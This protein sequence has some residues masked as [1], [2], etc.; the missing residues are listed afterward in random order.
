METYV[1][2]TAAQFGVRYTEHS[3]RWHQ[4][5]TVIK[6]AF[7]GADTDTDT[8]ILAD[9][10]ARIVERMSACRSAWHRNN[11]KKSGVGRV[12]EDPRED[13]HVGVCV[14]VGVVEF[15]LIRSAFANHVI[16]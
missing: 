9:I 14:G 5:E 4:L 1:R 3:Q 2:K 12:G 15:S 11:F 16:S 6:L 8:D 10:L 13:V 7:H